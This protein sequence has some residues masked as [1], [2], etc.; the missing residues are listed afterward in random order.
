MR[1]TLVD[2]DYLDKSNPDHILRTFRKIF[3]KAGMDA[4]EV[5]I[6]HGLFSRIDWIESKRQELIKK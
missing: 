4:R 5:R 1:K 6:L 3:G 2:I